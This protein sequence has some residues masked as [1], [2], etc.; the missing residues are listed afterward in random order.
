[1]GATPTPPPPPP[2]DEGR[3]KHLN[4]GSIP[5]EVATDEDTSSSRVFNTNNFMRNEFVGL[6]S[7]VGRP[8]KQDA[9]VKKVQREATVPARRRRLQSPF[10]KPIDQ[11]ENSSSLSVSPKTSVRNSSQ[12]GNSIDNLDFGPSFGSSGDFLR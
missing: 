11:S 12:G 7:D 2:D 10:K 4:K 9:R 5:T 1:M 8:N 6:M 3:E